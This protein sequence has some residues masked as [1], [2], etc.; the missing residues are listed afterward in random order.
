MDNVKRIDTER[1]PGGTWVLRDRIHGIIFGPRFSTQAEA[2]T[3][4][5]AENKRLETW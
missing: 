3:A 1:L 2:T 4:M 5:M